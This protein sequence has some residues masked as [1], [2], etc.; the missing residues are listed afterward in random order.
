MA[1]GSHDDAEQHDP[2]PRDRVAHSSQA[3]IHQERQ[4]CV[5]KCGMRRQIVDIHIPSQRSRITQALPPSSHPLS[6]RESA[7]RNPVAEIRAASSHPPYGRKLCC[8]S[9]A[10]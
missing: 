4:T 10:G 7:L 6:M 8:S 9:Y 3:G 2:E 1:E 5:G